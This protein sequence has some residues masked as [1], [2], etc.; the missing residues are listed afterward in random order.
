MPLG[1]ALIRLSLLHA[2]LQIKELPNGAKECPAMR[3][4][5]KWLQLAQHIRRLCIAAASGPCS[6]QA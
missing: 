3:V 1:C 5:P 4:F 6:A 2:L